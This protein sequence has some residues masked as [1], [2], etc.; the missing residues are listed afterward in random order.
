MIE[1]IYSYFTIEMLYI[2]VNI[3]VLPFW[4]LI[5]F[6]PQSNL[7]KYLATSI[8][9]VFLLSAAYGFMLYKSYMNGYDFLGNFD[10]YLGLSHVSDLFSDNSYLLLFWIHFVSI[11]L[12][13]GGWILKDSQRLF[14]NRILVSFPLIIT[15]LIG[16]IGLFVYWLIRMFYAKKFSIYD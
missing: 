3:G 4:F 11:N 12:F 1:Q 10:L 14:I 2:W 13:V 6:F 16:P 8:L 7:C 9:P 5:I 15:Y